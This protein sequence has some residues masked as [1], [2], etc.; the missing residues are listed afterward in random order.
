[1]ILLQSESFHHDR[2]HIVGHIL[3]SRPCSNIF[4]KTIWKT[5]EKAGRGEPG[6]S[7]ITELEW[8]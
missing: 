8:R 4:S 3:I 2:K 7:S 1:M 5:C 6:V